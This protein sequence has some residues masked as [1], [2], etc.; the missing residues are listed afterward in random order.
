MEKDKE[1]DGIKQEKERG[2]YYR[3]RPKFDDN[4]PSKLRQYFSKGMTYFL[5]IA[6]SIVFYFA[7]LRLTNLSDVFGK[8]VNVL[9]PI[10]Y[11]LVIAYLLNPIVRKTDQYLIPALE[12]KVKKPEKLS[13]GAG[14]LLSLIVLVFLITTLSNMLIPELYKSIRD[15]IVTLPG[16]LNDVMD[17]FN[18]IEIDDSTTGTL[19]KSAVQEGSQMFQNW[20]RT[21]LLK[22]ANEIMS[23]LTVGV[24]NILSELFNALIGII[25]SVYL[26]FSK[27]T[28][29]RQSKKAVYAILPIN[30]AN[31]L[32]HLAQKS[33]EIFGGFIIGKIIDSAIIGVICFLGLTAL[34]M[35]YTVLVSVIVGVTNVIPFFGPYIGAIPSAIL[36][37]LVDPIKGI[38]F[39]IFIILLQ[40]LDGNFIGPKILGNSTGLSA[41]WVIFSILLGGGLFGFM[42]MLMGVPTF[43]VIYYIIQMIINNRLEKKNLPA[44]SKYYDELSYVDDNGEYVFSEEHLMHVQK[45]EKAEKEA[46]KAT[47]EKTEEETEEETEKEIEES[48]E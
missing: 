17:K 43:A 18:A 12:N 35:P 20:L 23:S 4:G 29:V 37:M 42:G 28:F 40:Q 36:I 5:V 34:S 10:L 22:Q 26:L 2:G 13:R 21:D 46:E 3:N 38:Y 41:F 32:L 14:I 8:I 25:V 45:E 9:K 39:I 15:L 24:I 16:Q 27:E 30:R 1:R 19:V 6:A 44:H 7:L 33:N 47:E 31:F 11:G 48:E